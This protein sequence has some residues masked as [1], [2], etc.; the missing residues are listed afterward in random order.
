M[1]VFSKKKREEEDQKKAKGSA[2]SSFSLPSLFLS[3]TH[4]CFPSFLIPGCRYD[5]GNTNI[6]G[7]GTDLEKAIRQAA[8]DHEPAWETAGKKLGVEVWRIEKFKVRQTFC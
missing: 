8:G 4:V 1:C 5:L 3:L 6:A 7:L 2:L